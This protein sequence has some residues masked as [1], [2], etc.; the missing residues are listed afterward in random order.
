ML[1]REKINNLGGVFSAL[2]EYEVSGGV[3]PELNPFALS[4]RT[5][6]A[7]GD[8]VPINDSV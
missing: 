8:V 6:R 2:G 4:P 5:P 1:F 3:D 7:S